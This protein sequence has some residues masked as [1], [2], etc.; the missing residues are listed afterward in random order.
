MHLTTNSSISANP[1][2]RCGKPRITGK[3]WTEEVATFSGVSL[4]THTQTLCPDPK[5]QKIVEEKWE[6]EKAKSIKIKEDFDKRAA[7]KKEAR[8]QVKLNK[9][10]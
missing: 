7:E 2:P 9:K 5:C 4:V 8:A 3:T 1:C 10:K 6:I